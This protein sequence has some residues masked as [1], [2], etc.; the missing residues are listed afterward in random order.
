MSTP[1][2]IVIDGTVYTPQNRAAPKRDG[3]PYVIARCTGAGVH[4]GYLESRDSE[5]VV[6]LRDARRIWY[7]KGAATLSELAVSGAKHPMECKIA[8]AVDRHELRLG[9]VCELIH[10]QAKG[11]KM[12]QEV[13]AWTA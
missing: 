5:G 2:E 10:T 12:L 3:M 11:A 4:A 1:S 7:W 8:L 9:D 13:E 6:V